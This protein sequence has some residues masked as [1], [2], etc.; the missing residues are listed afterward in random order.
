MPA[1]GRKPSSSWS[2]AARAGDRHEC[3]PVSVRRPASIS[4]PY[5]RVH[6]AN[7]PRHGISSAASVVCRCPDLLCL[8]IREAQ[9]VEEF[10]KWLTFEGWTLVTPLTGAPTSKPCAARSASSA[11]PRG[12]T[13][14]AGLDYD[15]A[16]GQLLRRMT[17]EAPGA[18]YA[19]AVPSS[20]L[21]AALRVPQR[22]RDLLR[23]TVYEVRDDLTVKA[24]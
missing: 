14:D 7:V 1:K 5:L 17:D 24:H 10:S 8:G 15:I 13:S 11:R 12:T 23:V 19:I 6:K 18:R 3:S 22:I 21:K 4:W 20:A 2:S 16:Y 9:V